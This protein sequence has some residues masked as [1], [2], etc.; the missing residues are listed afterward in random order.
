MHYNYAEPTAERYWTIGKVLGA[1]FLWSFGAIFAYAT[2]R[3]IGTG[4]NIWTTM[5]G[6]TFAFS[7]FTI[8][9]FGYYLRNRDDEILC[10][11][12]ADFH[13]KPAIHFPGEKRGMP[14]SAALY[15]LFGTWLVCLEL[16]VNDDPLE[17]P[18]VF[19]L[20][21]LLFLSYT[22]FAVLGRFREDGTFLTEDGVT[23][24]A[25]GL[26]AQI[27]WASIAGTRTYKRHPFPFR[28]IAIDLHPG[29]PREV[30]TTVP[31]WVGSPR[32]RRDTVFLTQVQVPGFDFANDTTN[33]G[34][35]I[36]DVKLQLI[37]IDELA[38]QNAEKLASKLAD[39]APRGRRRHRPEEWDWN[40]R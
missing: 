18:G 26:R 9:L 21:G 29:T 31:W 3:D 19:V 11:Q 39:L 17:P 5:F 8:P 4:G 6:F 7:L 36:Q 12:F 16:G 27:P 15:F 23:I 25:R 32:P 33:P 13:G 20:L 30:S 1:A 37:S 34:T 38:P 35:W 14:V 24:C 40:L 22:L 2:F 28:R 10:P